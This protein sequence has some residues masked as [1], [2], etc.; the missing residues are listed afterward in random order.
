MKKIILLFLIF[1]APRYSLANDFTYSFINGHTFAREED[2][3]NKITKNGF[4]M[5]NPIL[6]LNINKNNY[7]IGKDSV[8]SSFIGYYRNFN[9]LVVGLYTHN[10]KDWKNSGLYAFNLK[11]NNSYGLIPII[12]YEFRQCKDQLCLKEVITPFTFSIGLSVKF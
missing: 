10:L 8:N 11:L 2:F 3:S 12:G 1:T 7:I 6:S 9:D 5:Y 4:L